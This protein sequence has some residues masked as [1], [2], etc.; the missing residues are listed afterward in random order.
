MLHLL[1]LSVFVESV[2]VG[3]IS[4][5]RVLALAAAFITCVSVLTRPRSRLLPSP[6]IGLPVAGLG[7][8]VFLSVFWAS[9]FS[10]WVEAALQFALALCYFGA[11]VVLL[12]SRAQ[13]R[14]LLTSYVVG[15]AASAVVGIVQASTTVRAV[16]LQG[17]ANTYA[18]YELAA[19]PVAVSRIGH[20]R[21]LARLGWAA[22][23]LLLL[24]AVL[25]AQSRGALLSAVA[26]VGFLL[27]RGDAGGI[28]LRRRGLMA[29]FGLLT[30]LIAAAVV[31]TKVPRFDPTVVR[32]SGGTGRVDIWR[33]AW[34]AWERRP[35]LGLGAGNFQAQSSDLLSTASGVQLD[36]YSKIVLGGIRVHN[37]YLEPWVELGPV[38]LALYLALLVGVGR[39]LMGKRL[40]HDSGV[41]VALF[42]M[43]L[44]FLVAT[45]F[46]S[47][48][49]NKLLWMLTGI[50]AVLPYLPIRRHELVRPVA[51][52]IE[53]S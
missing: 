44:G 53:V 20:T 2:A 31:V 17:D 25:S 30:T 26:V 38:G 10:S 37:A 13:I 23:T 46:L 1:V 4:V 50:A 24:W 15:A 16:G 35:V 43:L 32:E 49:N 33:V 40:G 21:G 51:S 19:V 41:L 28:W 22:L 39:I 18:L 34:Q 14:R 6:S 27:V 7:L 47:T 42:P 45:M 5:G 12:E 8:W 11:Y 29:G 48:M 52:P 36:P 9:S 3:P